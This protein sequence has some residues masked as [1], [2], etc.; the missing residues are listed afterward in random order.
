MMECAVM[1][2]IVNDV[3]KIPKVAEKVDVRIFNRDEEPELQKAYLKNV[4]GWNKTRAPETYPRLIYMKRDNFFSTN[5]IQN[6]NYQE[7]S[8]FLLGMIEM[9]EDMAK[10][11]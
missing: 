10:L 5:P 7:L 4:M 11:G 2:S 6:M 8:N 9:D 1:I 3:A